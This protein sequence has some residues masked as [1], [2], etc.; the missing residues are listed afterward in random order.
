M[1]NDP[2]GRSMD[3]EIAGERHDPEP[4]DPQRPA[5]ILLAADD[6]VCVDDACLPGDVQG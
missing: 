6:D 3:A 5:L 1:L 4:G 2:P